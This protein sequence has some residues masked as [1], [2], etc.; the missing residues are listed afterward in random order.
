MVGGVAAVSVSP[1]MSLTNIQVIGTD[2]LAA[3]DVAAALDKSLKTQRE[4][5]REVG[6]KRPNVISMIKTGEMKMP[7]DRIPAFAEACGIDPVQLIKT[8]MK[9]Y[10]PETWRVLVEAFEAPLTRNEAVILRAIRA[11]AAGHALD[12]RPDP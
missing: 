3:S 12:F 9:E 7:I 8:A 2:R 4:V 11:M 6:V 1:L 10:H 5:S